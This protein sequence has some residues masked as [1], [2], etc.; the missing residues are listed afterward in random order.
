V[1]IPAGYA[2]GDLAG[3]VPGDAQLRRVRDAVALID[4]L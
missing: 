1:E 3:G 4:P 2:I